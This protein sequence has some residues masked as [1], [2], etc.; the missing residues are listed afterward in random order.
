MA[1]VER[2][3]SLWACYRSGQ[4]SEAQWQTHLRENSAFAAYVREKIN[5]STDAISV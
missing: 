1:E 2:F 4:M 5:Y 3:E